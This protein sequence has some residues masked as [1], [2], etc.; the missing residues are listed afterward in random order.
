MLFSPVEHDL[1]V[2]VFH[3][4]QRRQ[5]LSVTQSLETVPLK[6]TRFFVPYP[7]RLLYACLLAFQRL[8]DPGKHSHLQSKLP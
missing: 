6:Q 8:G 2:D 4:S 5:D 7:N 1:K 3:Y